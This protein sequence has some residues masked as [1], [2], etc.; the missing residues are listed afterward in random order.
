VLWAGLLVSVLR[1]FSS[2]RRLWQLL[3]LHG[4]WDFPRRQ[5][6]S[7]AIYQRL[8][9]LPPNALQ[10]LFRQITAVLRQ[11]FSR[12]ND[13]PFALFAD[14]I[15]ALDHSTLDAVLRKAKPFRGCEKGSPQLL[16]GRIGALFDVR[17]QLW[18]HVEFYEDALAHARNGVEELL[19]HVPAGA[20]LL[21]DLGYFSFPWFDL[22]TDRGFR[23]I[24]RCKGRASH[25]LIHV[26]FASPGIGAG[27][28]EGGIGLRDS[29]VYLGRHR[30]DRAKHAVRLIEVFFPGRTFQYL[31]NV[32]DP[33]LL[34]ARDVVELYRRRWDIEQAFNLIKTHLQLYLV[35][36]GHANVVKLQLFATLIVSQVLL[37][38]RNQVAAEAKAPLRDVSLHGVII[39]MPQ[40]AAAGKDPVRELAAMGRD[41]GIIRPFRGREYS[42]P[43]PDPDKY[44]P[45]PEP[46]P[47]RTPRYSGKQ[48]K[49]GGGGDGAYC[50]GKG[51]RK[52]RTR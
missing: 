5:V 48:G 37:A 47:Q 14:E 50:R 39:W 24:S 49:G 31:T 42:V 4:L 22:L 18:M 27:S 19:A 28:P 33:S 34:P 16:P 12:L 51:C 3:T 46:P 32:L 15:V 7:Q 41:A 6:T 45:P 25:V 29:L 26:L 38:L 20:L 40:L 8:Q 13:V 43:Q 17:R 11:R 30:A 23:W 9:R 35:W 21:F 2:Q 44:K 52:K 1:G 36:S 10:D